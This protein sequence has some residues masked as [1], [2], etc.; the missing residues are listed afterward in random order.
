MM[1]RSIYRLPSQSEKTKGGVGSSIAAIV[2]HLLR[3]GPE[4]AAAVVCI[5]APHV[6]SLG[7][8]STSYSVPWQS[9]QAQT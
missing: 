8:L 4:F 6:A 2:H 5:I 9:A 1:K 7:L 3:R